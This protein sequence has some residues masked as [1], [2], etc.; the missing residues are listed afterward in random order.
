MRIYVTNANE[1]ETIIKEVLTETVAEWG[2]GDIAVTLDLCD[3]GFR[4][5]SDGNAV[6]LYYSD[7]TSLFRGLGVVVS[8]GNEA[9]DVAEELKLRHCGNMIDCS[10]NGVTKVATVKKFC[11]ISALMGFNMLQLYTEDTYE[12][13]GEPYFGHLRGR[14]TEEEL[15]EIDGYAAELGIE[16]IPCIQTLAHINTIFHWPEYQP[17]RDIDD[18]L[19]V[20]M[21]ETYT[22]IDK[23]LTATCCGLKSRRINIGMDEAHHIGLGRYL[24]THG[25]EKRSEIMKK[26]LERAVDICRRHGYEPMMWSDMFFRVCSKTDAY[27]DD[28]A[29][30]TNEVLSSVPEDVTMVLWCYYFTKSEEY[31]KN[32]D[33]HFLFNRKVSFAGG[34]WTHLGFV[35]FQKFAADT[36]RAAFS[37]LG[38]YPLESVFLTQWQNDGAETSVFTS[39][40]T[41]AIYA[42]GSW[43]GDTSV[44]SVTL[45]IKKFGAEYQDFMALDSFNKTDTTP[46][47]WGYKMH[48]YLLYGDVLQ[49]H[50]D[51]HVPKD[52]DEYF[53]RLAVELCEISRR[54]PKW[55]YIFDVYSALA[56]VLSVKARLG[57]KLKSAYDSDDKK[58]MRR[59][60]DEVIP[61][62]IKDIKALL[63]L[64]KK[65][66]ETDNKDFGFDVQEVRFGGLICRLDGTSDKI[67]DYL[68]GNIERI[69][70]LEA[71]RLG[72][73]SKYTEGI[74]VDTSEWKPSVAASVVNHQ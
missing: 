27:Y 40:P 7:K 11:R 41:M 36:S 24:D 35:P 61:S 32:L 72:Y 8:R 5:V 44:E 23:M 47:I 52:C 60:A 15:Q 38:N 42:E 71:P 65:R 45:C 10:R 54:N 34:A 28:S 50:W 29:V 39:L 51:V 19:N 18:I 31:Q 68:N 62:L 46:A 1:L 67:L 37:V 55:S 12:I 70:E 3:K 26:H 21:E 17:L 33:K 9:Y 20:G 59:I 49:G 57:I 22:L 14:Y 69:E 58:E 66:W 53:A 64:H 74:P 63:K 16:V 48:K 25:Y 30:I 13:E 56:K 2:E 6:T 43:S 73:T 4:A